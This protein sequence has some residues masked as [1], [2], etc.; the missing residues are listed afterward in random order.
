VNAV[1]DERD[2]RDMDAGDLDQELLIL[3][4]RVGDPRLREA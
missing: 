2:A 4:C 3:E 1:P